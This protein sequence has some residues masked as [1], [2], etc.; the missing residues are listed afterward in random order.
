MPLVGPNGAPD[1]EGPHYESEASCIVF[2]M[3]ISCQSYVS[4]TN[5]ALRL[6]LEMRLKATRKWLGSG[7]NP[8]NGRTFVGLNTYITVCKT[9]FHTITPIIQ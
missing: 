3:K 6:A 2:V 8:G 7:R 9:T 1:A 5:F 4:K